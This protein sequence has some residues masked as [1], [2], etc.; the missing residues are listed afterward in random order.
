[1]NDPQPI[2]Q[3][4]LEGDRLA[5]K[6]AIEALGDQGR[7]FRLHVLRTCTVEH[8]L[9]Y[10]QLALAAWKLNA[11]ISLSPLGEL[12]APTDPV[13]AI[14]IWWRLEDLAEDTLLQSYRHLSH[15]DN[16]RQL[17]EAHLERQMI[18]L[19]E[20]CQCPTWVHNFHL[21][22]WLAPQSLQPQNADGLLP[23]LYKLN[24]KLHEFCQDGPLSILAMDQWLMSRGAESSL[25]PRLDL[26]GKIPLH[27]DAMGAWAM[28]FAEHCQ[29]LNTPRRKV[30]AVDADNT[31]WGGILGED[32]IAQLN[33][34]A[35]F[36]GKIYRKIQHRL[37]E[38][39]ASGV[40][41]VLLS[42]NDPEAVLEVLNTHPD[43]LIKASDFIHICCNYE[44]KGQNIARAA[45]ELNLGLS[46]FAF[47][48]DQA[49]EREQMKSLQP[50]V[51]IL[52]DRDQPLDMLLALDHPELGYHQ[53]QPEDLNKHQ[54][55][56]QEQERQKFAHTFSQT[57]SEQQ[58]NTEDF[59]TSLELQLELREVDDMLLPRALQLLQKTNQFNLT[60]QRHGES[61]LRQWISGG[62]H[63][64]KMI[65]SKDR[66]G[67][68]G[69]VGLAIALRQED[70]L[71]IDTFLLSC[72]A[73]GRDIEKKL[74]EDLLCFGRQAKL[75]Q[76]LA[77]YHP[78]PR[79]G[80]VAQLWPNLGFE[81]LEASSPQQFLL[82]L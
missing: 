81:P 6:K 19:K 7:P 22:P 53:A 68:Q 82:R 69:W 65:S 54:Q 14:L 48:D 51:L 26:Y 1:M 16:T 43:S 59:L 35:D 42:K 13:D 3:I 78:T 17:F 15:S 25:D 28:F 5:I 64:L 58:A 73:L 41:L 62:Q 33:M 40:L 46:S 47:I 29:R 67:D 56:Q 79:N 50:E 52:N 55:Y 44:P 12:D 74:F 8:V 38:F 24:L 23:W 2:R 31:L 63:Y 4:L 72:R 37:L 76:I 75:R 60:T 80:L 34:G 21:P 39:K 20:Q 45:Q 11:T 71:V 61:Q 36:P 9:P 57:A 10:L 27:A 30:L 77:S 70:Q 18:R 66:F 49:F 32:G